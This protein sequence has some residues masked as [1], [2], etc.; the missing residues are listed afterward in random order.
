MIPSISFMKL[1]SHK[2]EFLKITLFLDT[3][4]VCAHTAPA[5]FGVMYLNQ[6]ILNVNSLWKSSEKAFKSFVAS[7]ESSSPHDDRPN[8]STVPKRFSLLCRFFSRF[9][10]F[11]VLTLPA[12]YSI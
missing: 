3:N 4:A 5:V 10:Q 9:G 2:T 8:N 12:I 7:E 11:S 1:Y 6:S